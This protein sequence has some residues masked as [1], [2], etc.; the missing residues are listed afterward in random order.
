MKAALTVSGW[1]LLV[2]ALALTV[3]AY[4]SGGDLLYVVLAVA[5]CAIS[6]QMFD[7]AERRR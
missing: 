5:L 2:P 4:T 6:W 3:K 7:I 1:A